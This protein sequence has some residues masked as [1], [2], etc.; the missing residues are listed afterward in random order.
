MSFQC[1]R[2]GA[3]VKD[4][5]GVLISGKYYGRDCAAT[6]LG[7][8]ELPIWFKAGD[9]EAELQTRNKIDES[10]R[11]QRAEREEKMASK[12]PLIH[13]VSVAYQK[14]RRSENEWEISFLQ[15][16]ATR[17]GMQFCKET[18]YLYE[19]FHDFIKCSNNYP[20]DIQDISV[21]SEKQKSLLSKLI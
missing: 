17:L 16:V 8:N 21:L 11:Q 20:D 10:L 18:A 12:W 15:N 7:L 19:S 6:I 14:A 1:S 9:W 13:S 5:N 2:C 4:E 3:D